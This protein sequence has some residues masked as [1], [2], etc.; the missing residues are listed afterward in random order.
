MRC[1]KHLDAL[2][3]VKSG[4][5]PIGIRSIFA[6]GQERKRVVQITGESRSS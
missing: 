3:L 6:S 1:A 4:H 2:V 5:I